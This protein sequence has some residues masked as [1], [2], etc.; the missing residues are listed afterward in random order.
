VGHS[1]GGRA[2]LLAAGRPEVRAAVALAPWV[3]PTDI[4][5]GLSDQRLLVV[6]GSED[7]VASPQRSAALARAIGATYVCVEGGKHAMLRHHAQFDGL[8][9]DFVT[10]ALLGM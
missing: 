8:A 10:A 2:A 7:R 4:P 1:L 6:H 3:Y 5:P 9:A